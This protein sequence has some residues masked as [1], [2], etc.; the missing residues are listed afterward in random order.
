MTYRDAKTGLFHW[1]EGQVFNSLF[2]ESFS[3]IVSILPVCS[4]VFVYQIK[5]DPIDS[6]AP[7]SE[8]NKP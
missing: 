4:I 7:V 6:T 8:I 2:F 3:I 1:I 5:I